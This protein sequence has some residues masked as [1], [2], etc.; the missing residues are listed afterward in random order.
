MK[1]D[2]EGETSWQFYNYKKDIF[3]GKIFESHQEVETEL[4]LQLNDRKTY[5]WLKE[6]TPKYTGHLIELGQWKGWSTNEKGDLFFKNDFKFNLLDL[7]LDFRYV[8][9]G[10]ILRFLDSENNISKLIAY[11]QDGDQ[12]GVYD[13]YDTQFYIDDLGKIYLENNYTP[14]REFDI[15]DAWEALAEYEAEKNSQFDDFDRMH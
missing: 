4:L 6:Y 7:N 3:F 14:P 13:W 1:I 12:D 9:G 11:C 10:P 15:F 2:K 5:F 8:D